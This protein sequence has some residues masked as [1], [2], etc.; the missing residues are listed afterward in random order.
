MSNK[1]RFHLDETDTG[2]QRIGARIGE[3]VAEI[4]RGHATVVPADVSP[5]P[6]KEKEQWRS[7]V[8]GNGSSDPTRSE[9]SGESSWLHVEAKE[10]VASIR[11]KK[12]RGK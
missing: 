11:R 6:G 10:I 7:E 9:N 8:E 5:R 4:L 2:V 1:H 12:R 3:A